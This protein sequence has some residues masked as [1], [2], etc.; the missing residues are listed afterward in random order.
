MGK[1]VRIPAFAE[2]I[3]A[4]REGESIS[5]TQRIPFS[6]GETNDTTGR[7]AKL[8][9]TVNQSVSKARQDGSNFKVESG[10]LITDDYSAMLIVVSVTRLGDD[11]GIVGEP[12]DEEMDI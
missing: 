12:D 2:L 7:V 10:A 8:R 1:M 6:D 5:R 4:L 3:R 11:G 9:N